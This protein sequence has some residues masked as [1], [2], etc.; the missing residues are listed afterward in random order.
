ML[1]D[2]AQVA[3]FITGTGSWR[4]GINMVHIVLTHVLV[5]FSLD[6]NAII[7]GRFRIQEWGD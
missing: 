2:G 1:Y 7:R 4:E 3:R 6:M 5:M